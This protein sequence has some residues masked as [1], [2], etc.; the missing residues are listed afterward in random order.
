MEWFEFKGCDVGVTYSGGRSA[1]EAVTGHGRFFYMKEGDAFVWAGGIAGVGVDVWDKYFGPV[2]ENETI[3]YGPN[4]L[5]AALGHKD[6][7]D[8]LVVTTESFLKAVGEKA[9][10]EQADLAAQLSKPLPPERKR[11]TLEDVKAQAEAQKKQ[12]AE[13]TAHAVAVTRAAAERGDPDCQFR[14]GERYRDGD[15]VPKDL[16]KAREWFGKSA[17][18][19]NKAAQKAIESSQK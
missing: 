5:R 3:W 12:A 14:M 11:L 8:T 4:G 7:G 9:D 15:G 6:T 16:E 19:G 10:K 13:L 17:A 18:G 2:P 1:Q